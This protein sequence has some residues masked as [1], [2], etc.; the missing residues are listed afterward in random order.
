MAEELDNSRLPLVVEYQYC[1]DHSLTVV[2]VFPNS[3]VKFY[4]V[5]YR[6][7]NN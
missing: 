6:K 4:L 7:S 2:F 5:M 3:A 1:L